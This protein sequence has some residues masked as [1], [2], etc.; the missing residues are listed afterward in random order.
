MQWIKQCGHEKNWGRDKWFVCTWQKTSTLGRVFFFFIVLKLLNPLHPNISIHILSTVRYIH[1]KLLTRRICFKIKSFFFWWSFSLILVTLMCDTGV[2]L[3][4]EIS[5]QS[6]S[7][8]KINISHPVG[9]RS[10][11]CPTSN[12]S[13]YTVCVCGICRHNVT[14]SHHLNA[15]EGLR[16]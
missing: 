13:F 15:F 9:Q 7:E 10:I 5:C 16:N 4:R 3:Y 6:L 8:I 2:I 12:Q 14:C 11:N 1:P